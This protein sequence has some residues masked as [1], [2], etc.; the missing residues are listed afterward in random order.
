MF[1]ENIIPVV[2]NRNETGMIIRLVG[3]MYYQATVN[4][5]A[6]PHAIVTVHVHK[7]NSTTN[8][9]VLTGFGLNEMYN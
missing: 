4:D 6:L 3:K 9:T 7:E 2:G 5:L 8:G 1:Q